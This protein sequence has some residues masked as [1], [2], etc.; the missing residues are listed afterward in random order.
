MNRFGVAIAAALGVLPTPVAAQSAPAIVAARDAGR[1]GERYDGYLGFV[2]PPEPALRHQIDSVNIRR[3]AFY[4]DLA[5]RKR[6]SPQEVGITAGCSLLATVEVGEA[7]QL[8]DGIWRR[9]PPG[10]PIALPPYC[11]P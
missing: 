5:G 9:R 4:T 1:I 11:R 10:E 7:Y 3:R 6:V 8:Q 2:V